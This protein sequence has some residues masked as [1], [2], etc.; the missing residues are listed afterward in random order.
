MRF[1]IPQTPRTSGASS[2]DYRASHKQNLDI[3][4]DDHATPPDSNKK[5]TRPVISQDQSYLEELMD[6]SEIN[7]I[8]DILADTHVESN[9]M[10]RLDRVAKGIAPSEATTETDNWMEDVFNTNIYGI[11]AEDDTNLNISNDI[12]LDQVSPNDDLTPDAV[13][14]PLDFSTQITMDNNIKSTRSAQT[15]LMDKTNIANGTPSSTK[16]KPMPSETEFSDIDYSLGPMVVEALSSFVDYFFKHYNQRFSTDSPNIKL[17]PRNE[18]I[19]DYLIKVHHQ[20]FNKTDIAKILNFFKNNNTHEDDSI[21]KLIMY[22]E[23]LKGKKMRDLNSLRSL[24]HYSHPMKSNSSEDLIPKL[25][26]ASQDRES[27][28]GSLNEVERLSIET[29]KNESGGAIFELNKFKILF[30]YHSGQ[31]FKFSEFDRKDEMVSTKGVQVGGIEEI[32]AQMLDLDVSRCFEDLCK[33]S[34]SSTFVLCHATLG[35]NE[36]SASLSPSSSTK[37]KNFDLALGNFISSVELLYHIPRKTDS[38]ASPSILNYQTSIS[39]YNKSQ[40]IHQKT[41][42]I[43]G[44]K[45]NPQLNNY[46]TYNLKIP[47]QSNFWGGYLTWLLNGSDDDDISDIIISQTISDEDNDNRD[48]IV[49]LLWDFDD[50]SSKKNSVTHQVF[51]IINNDNKTNTNS[52]LGTPVPRSSSTPHPPPILNSKLISTVITGGNGPKTK[53]THKRTR[54]KSFSEIEQQF[55]SVQPSVQQSLLNLRQQ[56]MVMGDPNISYNASQVPTRL[57]ISIDQSQ[58]FRQQDINSAPATQQRFLFY[59]P[60]LQLQLQHQYP[61][62]ADNT[63]YIVQQNSFQQSL[64]LM[65]RPINYKSQSYTNIPTYNPMVNL[66]QPPMRFIGVPTQLNYSNSQ[67]QQ[68]LPTPPQS[69][70]PFPNNAAYMNYQRKS[71]LPTSTSASVVG[72]PMQQQQQQQQR[73]KQQ[74]YVQERPI[75]ATRQG[76]VSSSSSSISSSGTIPFHSSPGNSNNGNGINFKKMK[77]NF[78]QLLKIEFYQPPKT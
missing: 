47:F 34:L 73:I 41:E 53:S 27:S 12:F 7:G 22:T 78:D 52:A 21:L 26:F 65:Q 15:P 46:D 32:K 9:T 66:Q 2:V 19:S 48:N 58:Q 61:Q 57:N 3:L 68:Q 45:V 49:T 29:R 31:N 24:E 25:K 36:E 8:N 72:L 23:K 5:T 33:N 13:I 56:Q 14:S 59:P 74:I 44:F 50:D 69:M 76:S 71:S 37:K 6:V 10:S 30:N 17:I 38:S 55:G 70:T 77:G 40:L 28:V 60:Q 42:P 75:K 35:L 39:I 67:H 20:S 64:P 63:P 4:P 54:S 62:S 16:K 18:Y 1:N 51:D 43:I 11:I